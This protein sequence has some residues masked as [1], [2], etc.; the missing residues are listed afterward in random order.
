[1]SESSSPDPGT[2]LLAAAGGVVP[3]HV[4]QRFDGPLL[5]ADIA[6]FVALRAAA[7]VN[8][9]YSNLAIVDLD[10]PNT[11]RLYHGTFLEPDVA[12]RYTDL[13][14]DAGFPIS[15][16]LRT[17]ESIV[18]AD[19]AAYRDRFPQFWEE[20][21]AVGVAATV[22]MPLF[23]PDG[24]TIGA[25]GFAWTEPPSFDLRLDTALT[26][27]AHLV[28]EIVQRSEI[29]EAEHQL[30]ADLHRRLLGDLPRVAGLVTSATYLPA[31]QSNAIGGDWYEGVLLDDGAVAV[32]V[33]DVVGHG[34]AAAA[35][36]ALIRGMVTALLHDGV[37]ID[38][39]FARVSRVLYRRPEDLLATAALVVID[40]AA[41][42]I[43]YSTAGHPPP[44]VV[45]QDGTVV[46]LDGA[47]TPLLGIRASRSA[48]ATVAFPP[49]A[50]LIMYT[51]G[52][53][54]TPDRSFDEGIDDLVAFVEELDT[55]TNPDDLIALVLA[56]MVT[57]ASAS[58]DIAVVV[59]EHVRTDAG[60][61]VSAR[62]P[63][64]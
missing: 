6:Q 22:S 11:F 55:S 47:N 1:M 58:D 48:S 62:D 31:G 50:T 10:A 3:A 7:C 14:V 64:R 9:D 4:P 59:V 53:V 29:Y 52:L 25:L 13:R 15:E 24:T 44:L 46:R 49:G 30:I 43:T 54:E 2:V 40:P 8:A 51:D 27:L 37:E 23:R 32:V 5:G 21:A 35:D 61:A 12:A 34:L 57:T 60:L 28:A 42:I 39:V 63:D 41:S 16:A 20:T 45:H 19:E 56:E 36:M 33:G 38:D 17:G 18:L 26:A